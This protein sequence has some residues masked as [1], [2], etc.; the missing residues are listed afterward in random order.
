MNFKRAS[1]F[2][3]V[4]ATFLAACNVSDDPVIKAPSD[5]CL[6]QP[7]SGNGTCTV[8]TFTSATTDAT[9]EKVA[10]CTCTGNFA[11][12]DCSTCADGF[13]LNGLVCEA[14]VAAE[15]CEATSCGDNG[16]C[17]DA[18]GSIVCT[19]TEGF[20]GDACDTCAAGYLSAEDTCVRN[21]PCAEADPCGAYGTCADSDTGV[22]CGC[23]AGYDGTRCDECIPTHFAAADGQC[24]EREACASDTCNN[25]GTCTD[26]TGLIDCACDA[27]YGGDRCEACY[28]GYVELNGACVLAQMCQAGTCFGKGT[29]DDSTGLVACTCEPGYAAPFCDGCA[30]GHTGADCLTCET[31]YTDV[32]GV[33]TAMCADGYYVAAEV[34]DDGNTDPSNGTTDFCSTDCGF[35]NWPDADVAWPGYI[36]STV[37]PAWAI[38]TS[39]QINGNPS[40]YGLVAAGS[41]VTVTGNWAYDRTASGCG[42]CVT[43]LYLGFFSEDATNADPLTGKPQWC[44]NYVSTQST[45][46]NTTITAPTEPGTYYLRWARS[47]DY[48][49][50]P[51]MSNYGMGANLFAIYVE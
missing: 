10:V 46:L 35:S 44:Q 47:W 7:C 32:N 11:G 8:S 50:N 14:I 13:E 40:H 23:E 37:G 41:S 36:A 1:I 3:I 22:T 25:R 15:T 9:V 18:T 21:I 17:D 42:G 20:G 39:M 16:T 43:Q 12:D 38:W 33:C 24:L 6:V 28:P 49:C 48:Q 27:T 2:L 26:T 34:C 19:C 51:T 5:P 45:A 29:C 30:I 4:T 31:G